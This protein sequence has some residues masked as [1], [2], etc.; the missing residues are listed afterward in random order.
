MAASRT[1]VARSLV[2]RSLTWATTALSR[3]L[4]SGEWRDRAGAYAIQGL[5]A[6]LIDRLGGRFLQRCGPALAVAF[7]AGS[8]ALPLDFQRVRGIAGKALDLWFILRSDPSPQ[9]R[10]AASCPFATFAR[11]CGYCDDPVPALFRGAEDLSGR[12]RRLRPNLS[13]GHLQK[14]HWIRRPRHG[15]GPRHRQHARVRPRPRDR[16]LRALRRRGGL[17][18]PARFTPSASRPSGCWAGRRARSPRSAH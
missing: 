6:T 16:A 9:V 8:R 15:G 18:P 10:L 3:Y 14:P 7:G 11:R 13:H 12:S 1:G 5:G 17:R 2:S 4:A